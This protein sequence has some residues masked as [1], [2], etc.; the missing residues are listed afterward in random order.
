MKTRY[1]VCGIGYDEDNRITDYEQCFGDFD[2]FEEA[3][4]VFVKLQC[5]SAES[6]FTNAPEVYQLLLQLEKC[7]EDDDDITCI[8]VKNEWRIVN[9]SF[10]FSAYTWNQYNG[11]Y[12]IDNKTT[13]DS[14]EEAIAFAEKYNWDG[15]M[16][17][18]TGEIVWENKEDE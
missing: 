8:D 14:K 2:T 7:E 13:F 5:R 4:E 18:G 15:V 12:F 6:F 17:N 11:I 3:Y 16:D 10:T 1:Y 9:P